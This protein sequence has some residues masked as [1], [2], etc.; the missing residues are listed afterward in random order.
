MG[1]FLAIEASLEHLANTL[2]NPKALVLANTLGEATEKILEYDKSP[3]R[4]LGQL[5]NRGSHFYLALYW[6]E[7]LSSQTQDTD[8]SKE[9]SPIAKALKENE[10]EIVKQL[11]SVQG[12]PI[13]IDG[14]YF[15][16][17]KKTY[18]AMQPSEILNK[19]LFS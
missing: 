17:E 5:D 16:N 2:N 10:L 19:I 14:Y 6:A 15:P 12:N 4:K 7:A 1:E 13:S 11:T 9:F 8:L 3:Q 18:Q